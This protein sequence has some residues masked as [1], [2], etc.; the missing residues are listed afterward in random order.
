M[1]GTQGKQR[2]YRTSFDALARRKKEK[3]S[4]RIPGTTILEN[5]MRKTIIKMIER[6]LASGGF[7]SRFL[8]TQ[9]KVRIRLISTL[10]ID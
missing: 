2:N 9:F 1:I 3:V 10:S 7:R 5:A 6:E 8:T 4:T